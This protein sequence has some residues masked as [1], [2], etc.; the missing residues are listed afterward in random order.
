MNVHTNEFSDPP[1]PYIDDRVIIT[2]VQLTPKYPPPPPQSSSKFSFSE[3]FKSALPPLQGTEDE[4]LKHKQNIV[5]DMLQSGVQGAD[6]GE[7]SK[8][9]VNLRT[10]LPPTT[11]K[12]VSMA[13]I[14]RN[15]DA[16]G[17]FDIQKAKELKIPEGRLYS[18]L[19]EGEDIEIHVKNEK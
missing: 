1:T 17:K 12:P 11:P 6:E 7:E 19:K 8:R 9:L 3:N 18:K 14:V 2:P 10:P 5:Y 15:K 4:I 13:Y 16:P